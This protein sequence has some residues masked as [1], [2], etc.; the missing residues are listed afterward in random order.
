MFGLY[1]NA[2][3]HHFVCDG[4]QK[5]FLARVK[6]K[7]QLKNACRQETYRAMILFLSI[8]PTG[9]FPYNTR[10]PGEEAFE[11]FLPIQ[12]LYV[13]CAGFTTKVKSIPVKKILISNGLPRYIAKQVKD[14][15]IVLFC[16]FTQGHLAGFA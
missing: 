5:S 10:P 15:L 4:K 3:I 13:S 8:H 6:N 7:W 1:K 9:T 2:S 11:I 12:L 16:C 14:G